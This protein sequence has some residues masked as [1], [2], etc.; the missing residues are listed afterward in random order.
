MSEGNV[1]I[2][3]RMYEAFHGGDAER[4]LAFFDPDVFVDAQ[5]VDVA[6]GRGREHLNQ[7][8]VSWIGAFEEWREEIDAIR[9][10]GSQVYV[11]LTQRGRGKGSGATVENR[12]AV[13]YE[14]NRDKIS[15]MTVYWDLADGLKAAG[16]SE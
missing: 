1:E 2:V 3:R 10:L 14:I 13:I 9:D 16:L 15:H 8:I 7:I 12:Y 5:R 11:E 6:A 4:A